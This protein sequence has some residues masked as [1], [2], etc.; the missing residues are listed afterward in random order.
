MITNS[1]TLQNSKKISFN[2]R[3]SGFKHKDD[4]SSITIDF[5]PDN[6]INELESLI[7]KSCRITVDFGRAVQQIHTVDRTSESDEYGTP[8]W[9]YNLAR[10]QLNVFPKLDCCASKINHVCDRYFTKE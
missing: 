9:L 7:S 10:T 2:G 5:T 4:M 8:V 3:M 6:K 1:M